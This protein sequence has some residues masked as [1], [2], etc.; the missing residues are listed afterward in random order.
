MIKYYESDSF[1]PYFNLAAEEYLFEHKGKYEKIVML[2]QNDNTIVIGRYQNTISEVIMPKVREL[3]VNVVRRNS[4]G[5]AV[6]HGKGNLNYSIITDKDDGVIRFE[7]FLQPIINVLESYGLNAEYT[8]RNDL[9]IDG[10]K[11][12]GSSQLI[13]D[14]KLLHHGTLLISENLDILKELLRGK[15]KDIISSCNKSNPS[16]VINVS[17]VL[18]RRID[19]EEMKKKICLELCDGKSV[20]RSFFSDTDLESINSLADTKYR[21]NEWNFSASP[22]YTMRK[23]R[24]FG[25]GTVELFLTVTKGIIKKIVF[26]GDFFCAYELDRLEK[27][28]E[29][30]AVDKLLRENLEKIEAG[31]YIYGVTAEDIAGLILE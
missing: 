4:G 9:M 30:L 7:K 6:Y 3:N 5:G 27:A 25:G 18:G 10:Y 13:K 20:V 11:I 15:S 12:S 26:N 14:K 8:S 1:D 31:K 21:T 19:I 22:D 2:W 29:G 28:M 16:K 24:K 23:K 17:D